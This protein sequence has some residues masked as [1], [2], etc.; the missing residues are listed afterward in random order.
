MTNKTKVILVQ[1]SGEEWQPGS[2][3]GH[4]TSDAYELALLNQALED[5]NISSD[6]MIQ[7]PKGTNRTFYRGTKRITPSAPSL[8]TLANNILERQPKVVGLEIMSCYES[9]ARELAKMIK[10]KDSSITIIAGGYHPSGYPEILKD[11]NGTIDYV[12]LGAGEKILP[13]LVQS[14]LKQKNPLEGRQLRNLPKLGDSK[15]KIAIN[16]SAY[17]TIDD[18]E[19]QLAER[20]DNDLVVSFDDLSIPKR[21][22]EYQNGSVSGVL[23]RI[24]PDKQVMATMQ[25]R[26]GCDANCTYCASSNVYG[27]KGKKLFSGSNVRSVNNVVNELEYL[28]DLGINFTF[29][30]DL[31]FN[32]DGKYM[33]ALTQ[34]IVEAKKK[35]KVSQEMAFYAMFRPFSMEQMKKRNL[36][37]GQ[38]HSLKKA[39]F[40]RIAFGVESP[41]DKTLKTF[42]RK[43]T[44]SDLE[45]HLKEI[46]DVGIFTRGFMMYGHEKETMESLGKYRQMMKN[47][48]VDEWRLAPMSPFVGTSTGDAYLSKQKSIDFSK[49]DA[50]FPVVIP[51]AIM[52]NYNYEGSYAEDEAKAFLI[53]WKKSTLKSI[54]ESKEWETRMDD[55]YKK[56]PE[57]REGIDFYFEYLKEN[58]K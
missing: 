15:R 56:F 40:T 53:N 16:Q 5:A 12:I 32:E 11:S 23:S 25:T 31:A 21:K 34:G 9:N 10:E 51:S 4:S 13:A 37:M 43:N 19:I 38:Y 44:I 3:R 54:Y 49:H 6:Y 36:D 52:A 33:E 30:T 2:T 55:K 26:R 41:D 8:E 47:L 28:S 18:G 7:R 45:K 58:L 57:L 27:S 17:A 29:F 48:H 39:G 1:P 46:H 24:T 20:L 42:K 50:N 14:I 35:G 22:M